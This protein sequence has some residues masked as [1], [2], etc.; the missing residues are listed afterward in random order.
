MQRSLKA[1]AAALVSAAAS[2]PPATSAQPSNG[3]SQRT[4]TSKDAS[5]KGQMFPGMSPRGMQ[6]S[7]KASAAALVSAAAS[8]PPATSVDSESITSKDASSNGQT[9]PGMSPRELKRLHHAW[10]V[11]KVNDAGF[12]A[13]I[14]RQYPNLD[15]KTKELLERMKGTQK[16]S[17]MKL[18]TTLRGYPD[19]CSSPDDQQQSSRFRNEVGLK[20]DSDD[21]GRNPLGSTRGVNGHLGHSQ[22]NCV[23]QGQSR[24][25]SPRP[26]D[27][28]KMQALKQKIGHG[29]RRHYH[30][31]SGFFWPEGGGGTS[32][33]TSFEPMMMEAAAGV[34]T[35]RAGPKSWAPSVEMPRSD[36]ARNSGSTVVEAPFATNHLHGF[37]NRSLSKHSTEGMDLHV[38]AEGI[39]RQ[40]DSFQPT[41]EGVGSQASAEGVSR[42]VIGPAS[43]DCPSPQTTQ[44]R[45]LK[46]ATGENGYPAQWRTASQDIIRWDTDVPVASPLQSPRLPDGRRQRRHYSSAQPLNTDVPEA[47]LP[48]SQQLPG[49]H[50]LRQRRHYPSAQPATDFWYPGAGSGRNV[51]SGTDLRGSPPIDFCTVDR[52]L[53]GQNPELSLS[54]DNLQFSPRSFRS[55]CPESSWSSDNLQFSPRS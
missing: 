53:R 51:Q 13:H 10:D 1:S 2:S 39:S 34:V 38:T 23:L 55:Q 52:R 44:R 46:G 8:S 50:H 21:V 15:A 47:S 6:R 9:F 31:N 43:K 35:G 41:A 25:L 54:S 11:G 45:M 32:S 36:T 3:F 29:H 16:L 26:W 42:Q 14:H 40:G 22:S 37:G 49:G 7:L 20:L 4:T 18:I 48:K 28:K 27:P 5:S 19:R 33:C 17:L 24:S 12:Q 30:T